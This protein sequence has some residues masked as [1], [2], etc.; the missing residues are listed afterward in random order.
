M[1][2]QTAVAV[3]TPKETRPELIINGV[4]VSNLF[5]TIDAIGND[6]AIANFQFR[7]KNTWID[8]GLNEFT[9]KDFFGALHE[10]TSREVPFAFKADEPEVLLGE[11]RGP[12]PVEFLLG[13]LS[14]CMTTTLAYKLAARGIEVDSISS[15]YQGDI[16]LH[17]FLDLDATVRSGFN[18]IRVNFKVK[19]DADKR[20]IEELVRTSPVYDMIANPVPIKV[21]VE[22]E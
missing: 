8:G 10:H 14:A 15:D 3:T 1:N 18:N 11:D 2:T 7:A 19:S 9:F 6:P 4:N 12:N 13:A 20:L 16:D 17:G 5:A 21:N 22:C